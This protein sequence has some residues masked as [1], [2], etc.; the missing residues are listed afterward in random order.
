MQLF[1][2]AKINIGLNVT[3]KRNDGYHNL[4][5][6]FFP[7]GLRDALYV[8]KSDRLNNQKTDFTLQEFGIE[9]TNNPERNLVIKAL[10]LLKED[11]DMDAVDIHLRKNI[12]LGAGLGGGSSDAANMLIALNQLFEL[13][14][15]DTELEKY[16]VKIGADCPFFIRN[17]P[18]FATGIGN[19][20]QPVEL[21]LSGWNFVLVKPDVHVT[22]ADAYTSISPKQPSI[23]L[24]EK[25]KLPVESWKDN[26][27]NDFES[28]IF[29]KYPVIEEV[30]TTF[31]KMGAEFALMSGS[32]SSVYGLFK[33]IPE[34][35]KAF[36]KFFVFVDTF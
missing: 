35:L 20:F 31:Y 5:T 21:N 6:V 14:L 24:L 34:G 18:V 16:A 15:S 22:T 11:F 36:D 32:G 9:V 23:S 17:T 30:K 26:I 4:E 29:K 1:P 12:P 13:N 2:N 19:I 28:I 27:F 3:E 7:I 25:I 8:E 33:E 10:Q